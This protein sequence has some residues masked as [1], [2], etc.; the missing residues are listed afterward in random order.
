MLYF[1]LAIVF[2]F[3]ACVG[4]FL[5]VCAYRLPFEKSVLWPGSRCGSCLQ[6]VRW[7][8][9]L[10]LLSYWLLRGRC[11]DCGATFSSR[12]FWVELATGLAFLGL[13]Y[14]EVILNVLDLPLIRKEAANIADGLIPAASDRRIRLSRRPASVSCSPRRCAIWNTWR[15]RCR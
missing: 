6:P 9:N 7:Y 1:V 4:S 11:R 10:P 2:L 5:N 8:D 14:L 15:S 12:Y 3:G 13:F